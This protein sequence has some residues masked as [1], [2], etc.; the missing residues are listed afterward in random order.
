MTFSDVTNSLGIVQ[1]VRSFMRVDSNQWPTS[2][3]VNSVNNYLDRVTGYA[4]GADSRFQFD[5]TNHSKLPIGT[6]NLV[7]NQTDYS[8]LTDEQGNRIL[9]LTRIDVKNSDGVWTQLTPIDQKEIGVALDEASRTASL[10]THYDK[11]A[12]NI[13]R[14]YPTPETSVTAGIKFY[15]QRTPS[16]FVATDTTK[17]PGVAPVLHRG[18]VMA[19]AFDGALTLGLPNLQPLS[20]EMQKEEQFMK[21]YFT[22][23]N[24]DSVLIMKPVINNSH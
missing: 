21:D 23:R 18:F 3:I 22:N 11:I 2:K 10:P 16:Y 13:I 17:E 24:N 8:F 15:F 6:T 14:L 19:G 1:Q 20:I 4:I 12:D 7:A 9:T 5:D